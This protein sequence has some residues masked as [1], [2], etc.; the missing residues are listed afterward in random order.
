MFAL[1]RR[2]IFENL[3][4]QTVAHLCRGKGFRNHPM[5]ETAPSARALSIRSTTVAESVA[6]LSATAMLVLRPSGQECAHLLNSKTNSVAGRHLGGNIACQR[7]LR[8]HR[9]PRP[10]IRDGRSADFYRAFVLRACSL[11]CCGTTKCVVRPS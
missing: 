7:L 10:R 4:V 3:G 2:I 11:I 6:P 9:F 5:G 8:F 1:W